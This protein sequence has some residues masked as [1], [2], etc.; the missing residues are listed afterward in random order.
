M[1]NRIKVVLD[2]NV[3]VSALWSDNGNPA[4]I[5]K[6]IPAVLIPCFDHT[7]F[8]E[9]TQ[10]LLRPK[11]DFSARRKEELLSRLKKYGEIVSPN[12]SDI[13][14]LDESDR[15]FYDVA[16]ASGAILITGNRRHYPAESFIMTPSDF[17]KKAAGTE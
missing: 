10:V 6:L 1:K 3:L 9:Y 15:V 8:L 11:F 7:I 13:H 4:A 5:M 17:L 2:T 12:K 14:F 16:Q